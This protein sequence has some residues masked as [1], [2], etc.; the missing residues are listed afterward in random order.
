MK[1]QAALCLSFV[2]LTVTG[3]LCLS[4]PAE[5]QP[6]PPAEP[7]ATSSDQSPV[8]AADVQ[9]DEKESQYFVDIQNAKR[10]LEGDPFLYPTDQMFREFEREPI[11]R[12]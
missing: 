11:C 12:R 10:Y 6:V 7:S 9:P 5:N 4:P 1:Q 8:P 2:A 3:Y